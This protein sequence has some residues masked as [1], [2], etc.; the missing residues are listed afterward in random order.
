M[1][2]QPMNLN[3]VMPGEEDDDD[4]LD[5]ADESGPMVI[6]FPGFT[7]GHEFTFH[8]DFGDSNEFNVRVVDIRERAD[9]RVKYPRVVAKEGKAPPQYRRWE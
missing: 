3:F 9:P 7:V 6:G 4:S 2:F 8:Y 1:I 5:T